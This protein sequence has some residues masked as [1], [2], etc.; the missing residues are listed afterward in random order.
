M[1]QSTLSHHME[2]KS[3]YSVGVVELDNQH[4][5]LIEIIN[6]LVDVI[7]R[8]PDEEQ[9]KKIIAEIV[10]YKAEHFAT[11][12]KYFHQFNYEGTEEHEARHHDFN[13][14]IEALQAKNQG[15]AIGFAFE[16]VEFLEDWFI[17]HLLSMDKKY[18]KCF[19]EHGLH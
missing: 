7:G 16:L 2:W 1:I 17:G 11:E 13:S 6:Q 12:E 15:D 3:E 10:A 19:N 5:K 4:K 18:T 14:Q 8:V 9:V